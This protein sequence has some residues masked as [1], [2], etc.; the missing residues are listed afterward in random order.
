LFD[1]VLTIVATDDVET[2]IRRI[3]GFVLCVESMIYND[4][5]QSVA[6]GIS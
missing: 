4:V 3:D 5:R 6:D 2:F 1:V